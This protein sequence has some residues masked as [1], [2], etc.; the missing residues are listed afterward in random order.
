[1]PIL[2]Y[3]TRV[4]PDGTIVLPPELHAAYCGHEVLVLI[5]GEIDK[6]SNLPVI[7]LFFK[8]RTSIHGLTDEEIKPELEGESP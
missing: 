6:E 5:D 2:Q 3:E 4:S 7:R 8:S 1:M